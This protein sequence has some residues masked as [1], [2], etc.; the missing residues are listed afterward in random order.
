MKTGPEDYG[1]NTPNQRRALIGYRTLASD[2]VRFCGFSG[3]LQFADRLSCPDCYSVGPVHYRAN[4]F[5]VFSYRALPGSRLGRDGN[6]RLSLLGERLVYRSSAVAGGIARLADQR[7]WLPGSFS[8]CGVYYGAFAEQG[9]TND[10]HYHWR[11]GDW[12]AAPITARRLGPWFRPVTHARRG[13]ALR[14]VLCRTVLIGDVVR[15]S[16]RRHRSRLEAQ[17]VGLQRAE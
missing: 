2:A 1:H 4:F 5:V 10:F 9:W 14:S 7:I 17:I 16:A 3:R 6:D 13:R 11:R 12:F 15:D 8:G